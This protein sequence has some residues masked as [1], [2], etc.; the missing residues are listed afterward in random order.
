M[1]LRS[2]LSVIAITAVAAPVAAVQEPTDVGLPPDLVEGVV[3]FLNDSTT[4]RLNGYTRIAPGQSV[5]GAVG[6]VGGDVEVAGTIDGDLLLVNGDLTVAPGGRITGDV[7]IVGGRVIAAADDAVG[8]EIQVHA[9]RLRLVARRGGVEV[10]PTATANRQGLYIGG[11]RITVRSGTNYNRV[12]G[13]P[14]LFGPVFRTSGPNPLRVDALAIWRTEHDQT[15]D[16]LGFQVAV[17]QTFGPATARMGVGLGA[18]SRVAPIES[19]GLTD[20]EASLSSFFFHEDY[21]DYFE[22]RGWHAWAR[23]QIPGTAAEFQLEYRNRDLTAVPTGSPW[24]LRRNDRPWRAQPL[25]PEGDLQTLTARLIWDERN[26]ADDPTDGWYFSGRVTRGLAGSLLL[27]VPVDEFLEPSGDPTPVDAGFT[28]GFVEFRRYARLSPDHD[29]SL[30]LIAAGSL[31]GDL[32]PAFYQHTLGGEGSLPGYRL[33]ELD[34]GARSSLLPYVHRGTGEPEPA[35]GRYGCSRIAHFQLQ[36]RGRL[37]IDALRGDAGPNLSEGSGWFDG[38]DLDPRWL[39][40]FDAGRAWSQDGDFADEPSVADIGAGITV[41]GVGAYWA[42]P[43]S[44]D[45]RRVNF[46]LRLQ[47]R[48]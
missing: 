17:D 37:P 44:G 13:L 27:P 35:Y 30:R 15:R 31:D 34:C 39:L 5:V 28:T 23:A 45:H 14:V 20:L 1:T 19:W 11:A 43:L 41:G 6:V 16:D 29:L 7:L 12:E 48:F 33:F 4:T 46:F 42:Y 10:T 21:R 36:Y 25:V 47:R 26:D 24:T 2:L 40:F 8:G 32:Q 18:F 38:V 9:D 22:E 3:A